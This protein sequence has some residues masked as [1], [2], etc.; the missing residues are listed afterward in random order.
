MYDLLFHCKFA[1]CCCFKAAHVLSQC[2][3]FLPLETTLCRRTCSINNI[4][5]ITE[6]QPRNVLQLQGAVFFPPSGFMSSPTAGLSHTELA[7]L[8]LLVNMLACQWGL[9]RSAVHIFA[10]PTC[11]YVLCRRG[12]TVPSTPIPLSLRKKVS[13]KNTNIRLLTCSYRCTVRG[14]QVSFISLTCFFFPAKGDL[15]RW[16]KGHR[17]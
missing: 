7:V 13:L 3:I 1:S 15:R 6:P 9:C 16:K 10:K 17:G 4:I 2:F 5:I 11:V 12:K 8:W 14:D